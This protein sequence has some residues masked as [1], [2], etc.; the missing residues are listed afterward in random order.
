MKT[1]NPSEN[2]AAPDRSPPTSCSR[3]VGHPWS[4]GQRIDPREA[5]TWTANLILMG[6]GTPSVAFRCAA[7][8]AED[9]E[10]NPEKFAA[11]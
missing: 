7:L 1:G 2:K 4:D 11:R 5:G 10:Q 6:G 8:I 9:I 3:L